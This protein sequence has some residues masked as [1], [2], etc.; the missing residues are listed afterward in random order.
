MTSSPSSLLILGTGALATLFAARL[1]A[2]GYAVTILGT[3]AEALD[4]FAAHGARIQ[5]PDGREEAHPVSVARSPQE[6]MPA[7][8]AIVLNKAWQTERTA[9]WLAEILPADGLALTLQNGLGNDEILIQA[10]GR[11]R[12]AAGITIVGATVVAPGVV[13]PSGMPRVSL[14]EHPRLEPLRL[15]LAAAGFD[16]EVAADVQGVIWGKLAINAGL[17]PLTAL[18]GVPNGGLLE[19]PAARLFMHRAAE[20]VAAVAAAQGITLPYDDAAAA[21]E[22]VAR[23]TAPNLSS[24]LQDLRRGAPT[25]IDAICGAVARIGAQIGT[26]APLNE[27]LWAMVRERVAKRQSSSRLSP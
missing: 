20:E 12:V 25:E 14:G 18:L 22:D 5:W 11:E 21:V 4:A 3:W 2:A 15:A 16:V 13:R 6:A 23:R 26:P 17:N 27:A 10:L 24:M 8:Y 1:S 19:D 9:R 7:R